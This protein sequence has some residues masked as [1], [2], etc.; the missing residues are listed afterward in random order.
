MVNSY[1]STID[2]YIVS[3]NDVELFGHHYPE[4]KTLLANIVEQNNIKVQK[5]S[6][7]IN[8]LPI[9]T[10]PETSRLSTWST[11]KCDHQENIPLP[12][13]NNPKN[14]IQQKYIGLMKYAEELLSKHDKPLNDIGLKFTSAEEHA[15]IGFSSCHLYWLSN[16][17]WWHPNIAEEGAQ[18]LVRSIRSLPNSK[19]EKLKAEEMYRA[20][21]EKL[22]NSH[23]NN[24][25]Q[26][27]YD[28]FNA[29]REEYIA[30]LRSIFDNKAP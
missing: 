18:N 12:L 1:L 23:W 30:D 4:R 27:G 3:V 15:H 25:Q 24:E 8:E 5:L 14:E 22:W 11:R 16:F 7:T 10:T 20:F 13:W 26:K 28:L 2:G 17:P 21:L 9:S 29:Y 19:E 6:T